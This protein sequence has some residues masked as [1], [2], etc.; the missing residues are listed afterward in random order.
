MVGSTHQAW[1]PAFSHCY[2][3]EPPLI[4]RGDAGS[5]SP[6][7][8]PT[9]DDANDGGSGGASVGVGREA[10][11][12]DGAPGVD[13]NQTGDD[14]DESR[15]SSK[16]RRSLSS[17]DLPMDDARSLSEAS[18]LV[19]NRPADLR[20]LSGHGLGLPLSRVYARYFGGDLEVRSVEG[21]GTDCYLFLNRLG[22]NCEAMPSV[23]QAS[24]AGRDSTEHPSPDIERR[25]GR[26]RQRYLDR[27]RESGENEGTAGS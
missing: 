21:F 10:G 26:Y 1:D 2:S 14:D 5:G 20:S 16:R 3:A 8:R 18:T 17:M 15:A 22:D 7:A 9:Y 23:V 13:Q 27:T 6:R 11:A 19:G 24:P 12:T 4:G 25:G